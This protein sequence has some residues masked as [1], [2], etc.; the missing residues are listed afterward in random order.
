MEM[1]GWNCFFLRPSI[2]LITLRKLKKY[3]FSRMQSK[4]SGT[5]LIT[6]ETSVIILSVPRCV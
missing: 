3:F 6:M 4:E 1:D 5:Y 2:R